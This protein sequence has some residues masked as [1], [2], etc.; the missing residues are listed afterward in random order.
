M[1]QPLPHLPDAR[2]RLAVLWRA[3]NLESPNKQYIN[4]YTLCFLQL[5]AN[6]M[7]EINFTGYLCCSDLDAVKVRFILETINDHR[8]GGEGE[9]LITKIPQY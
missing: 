5:L 7:A 3:C 1:V 4:P 8:Q 2:A 6:I 9:I